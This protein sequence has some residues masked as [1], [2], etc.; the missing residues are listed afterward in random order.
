MVHGRID[1]PSLWGCICPYEPFWRLMAQEKSKTTVIILSFI[2][3]A[4]LGMAFAAVP[5]YRL[6]CQKTGFGGT[7]QR[8]NELSNQITDRVIT[9]RFNADI[10]RDLPWRFRPMQTQIKVRVGENALAFYES[11]SYA[12]RP[13]V[14]MATYNVTPDKAGIYFKKVVCF[15]FEEQQLH[16]HQRV[17]MPVYFFI[18]PHF[19]EDPAMKDVETIT[20]SYTFFEYKN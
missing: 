20:L 7:T 6:F 17:E 4:M 9:V 5:I 19:A 13:I 1:G 15:C 2:A 3:L 18:D 11:E 14:G 12:D 8:A 16:P 10:H